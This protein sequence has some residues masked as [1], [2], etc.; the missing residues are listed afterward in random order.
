MAAQMTPK[1]TA[2]HWIDCWEAKLDVAVEGGKT[3]Q[4][5]IRALAREDPSLHRRYLYGVNFLAGRVIAADRLL[6]EEMAAM[7]G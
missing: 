1:Q 3:R 4:Q 5:A 2:R 6:K 7:Q